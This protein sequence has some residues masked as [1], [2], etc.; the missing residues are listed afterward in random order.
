MQARLN[1]SPRTVIITGAAAGVGR[2]I[3]RRFAAAGDR[4]GLIAR[5]ATALEKVRQE[6]QALGAEAELESAD[7]SDAGAVFAAAERLE[8]RL[9]KVDIWINDAMVTVFS[10]VSEITPEEFR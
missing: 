7:V 1:P 8:Q 2:A 6:L 10:P 3:A 4:V 5:D 9:G